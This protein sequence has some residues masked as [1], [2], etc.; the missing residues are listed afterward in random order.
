M[1]LL[2]FE[3]LLALL[4][5]FYDKNYIFIYSNNFWDN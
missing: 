1:S 3:S 4:S 5:N 2:I